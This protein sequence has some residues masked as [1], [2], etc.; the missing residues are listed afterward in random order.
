MLAPG[1]PQN[2]DSVDEGGR[3][4]TGLDGVRPG[5]RVISRAHLAGM[6][7]VIQQLRLITRRRGGY[8]FNFSQAPDGEPNDLNHSQSEFVSQRVNET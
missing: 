3:G 2:H 6:I 5:L 1:G 4:Q 7:E 8:I